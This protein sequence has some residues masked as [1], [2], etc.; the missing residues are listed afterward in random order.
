MRWFVEHAVLLL[1]R[2]CLVGVDG[3]VTTPSVHDQTAERLRRAGRPVSVLHNFPV[4]S[5]AVAA[6]N[7]PSPPTAIYIGGL[8]RRKG[9]FEMLDAVAPPS[10]SFRRRSSWTFSGVG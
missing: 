2:V 5:K 9:L 8:Q 7:F 1:E 6:K 3:V 10:G 4:A